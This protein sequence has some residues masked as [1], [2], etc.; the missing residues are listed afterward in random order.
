[1][2]SHWPPV[3]F[4]VREMMRLTAGCTIIR[5]R[6]LSIRALRRTRRVCLS[7]TPKTRA[8]PWPNGFSLICRE[9]QYASGRHRP[10]TGDFR[11]YVPYFGIILAILCLTRI[12]RGPIIHLVLS[13]LS[14]SA[15]SILWNRVFEVKG[16][17]A[18]VEFYEARHRADAGH[19]PEGSDSA[20]TAG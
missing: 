13:A 7:A 14:L 1:M 4:P 9:L 19:G 8:I 17:H 2:A 16:G 18:S 5:V 12:W 20:P 10:K 6:H 3:N 15:G 11:R